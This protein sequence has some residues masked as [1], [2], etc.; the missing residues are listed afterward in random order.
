MGFFD[1]LVVIDDQG[2]AVGAGEA[3]L[4]AVGE[5][6]EITGGRDSLDETG[7]AEVGLRPW[8]FDFASDA[9]ITRGA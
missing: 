8:L 6:G 1:D 3:D 2:F 4:L 9:Y 5:V 7:L